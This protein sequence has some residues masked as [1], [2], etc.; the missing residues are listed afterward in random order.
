VIVSSHSGR[1][2][3]QVVEEKRMKPVAP[4][5]SEAIKAPVKP[6]SDCIGPEAES[7]VKAAK[8]GEVVL[9]ENLRFHIEETKNNPDFSKKVGFEGQ[10]GTEDGCPPTHAPAPLVQQ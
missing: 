8:D 9:L 6:A 5:L 2:K 1:P 10:A 3:G 4:I 7:V